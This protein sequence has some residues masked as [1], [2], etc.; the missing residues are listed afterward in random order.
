[1]EFITT[2]K[3]SEDTLKL[4]TI[5]Q[6]SPKNTNHDIIY[7][8]NY[9]TIK[10]EQHTTLIHHTTTTTNRRKA[11]MSIGSIF[12]FVHVRYLVNRFTVFFFILTTPSDFFLRYTLWTLTITSRDSMFY[13]PGVC[14]IS[15]YT[16][17]FKKLQTGMER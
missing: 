6:N 15:I 10:K 1:M 4:S 7:R 11:T 8:A 2:Q 12:N 13:Q 17:I 14:Y 3:I 5:F 9:Q 16:V